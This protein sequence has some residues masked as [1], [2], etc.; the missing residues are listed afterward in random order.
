MHKAKDDDERTK[1]KD[2]KKH[3]QETM[4]VRR[5]WEGGESDESEEWVRMREEPG[6]P[7]IKLKR[8][9]KSCWCEPTEWAEKLL[10]CP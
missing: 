4:Q 7:K 9:P 1:E 10:G 2:L 8:C 3:V 6:Q 5:E